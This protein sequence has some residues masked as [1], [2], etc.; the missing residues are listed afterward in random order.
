[1]DL[2]NSKILSNDVI[3]IATYKAI[4]REVR[5]ANGFVPKTCWTADVLDLLRN[6]PLVAPNRIDRRAR[7]SP[8]PEEKRRAII[9]ALRKLGGRDDD[10]R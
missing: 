1:M 4:Q 3:M 10:S 9:E 5:T 7:E 2:D 6:R 8:C